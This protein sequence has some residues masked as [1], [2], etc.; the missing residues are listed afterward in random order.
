MQFPLALVKGMEG[1]GRDGRPGLGSWEQRQEGR[2]SLEPE[3][4]SPPAPASMEDDTSLR[5]GQIPGIAG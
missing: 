2:A 3:G 5:L 4:P 1:G